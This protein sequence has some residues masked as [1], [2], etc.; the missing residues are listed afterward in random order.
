[1][2]VKAA[3]WLAGVIVL[4]AVWINLAVRDAAVILP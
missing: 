3:A 2:S 1:M 4:V